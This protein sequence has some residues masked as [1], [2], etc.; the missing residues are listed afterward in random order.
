VADERVIVVSIPSAQPNAFARTAPPEPKRAIE[1]AICYLVLSW[2]S[3]LVELGGVVFA[4]RSGMPVLG[5]LIFGLAY[6]LG[7][8]FKNPLELRESQYR[9]LVLAASVTACIGVWYVWCVPLS[10]SL[11]SA[12]LAG[13]REEARGR[14][15]IGTL[16]KRLSR[17][18]GFAS[19]GLFVPWTLAIL[20][21]V[22]LVIAKAQHAKVSGPAR[23]SRIVWRRP[24][25]TLGLT[26]VV[27][28]MHYF[29]YSY[30]L[31]YLFV[32]LHGLHT[33]SC[34]LAFAVGWISYSLTP[35][36]LGRLPV[37]PTVVVGHL[38]VAAS[39]VLMRSGYENL[40]IL[41]ATWFLT[42]FGGGTVFG[43]RRLSVEWPPFH[44]SSD[45]DMWENVGHVLGV[46]LGIGVVAFFS[47]V[48]S[49]FITGAVLALCVAGAVGL[50][51]FIR[52]T[53]RATARYVPPEEAR[54][55]KSPQSRE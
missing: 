28:Q 14:C 48:D 12:G 35:T 52:R 23:K 8:L 15:A 9:W 44:T 39:L 47:K 20:G 55:D 21:L 18:V 33:T 29:V 46:A 25:G 32:G 51:E 7:C 37:V 19:V 49:L 45:L 31:P 3:G 36:I 22:I 40:P 4:I 50:S 5:V 42:G 13:I 26:M 24:L 11:L 53:W 30:A 2:M 43:I 16:S 10:I 34:G 1:P 54:W 27:H 38:G 41:L 6:Q 17:I